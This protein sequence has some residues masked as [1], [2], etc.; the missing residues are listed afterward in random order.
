MITLHQTNRAGPITINP[1]HIVSYHRCRGTF[2][3]YTL[4]H[5]VNR[6][7]IE[8]DELP[9]DITRLIRETSS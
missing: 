4:I 8:V 3:D 1:T 7:P 5:M 2:S 6:P 9:V